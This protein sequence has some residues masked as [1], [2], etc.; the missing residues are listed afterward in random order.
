MTKGHC[1][2]FVIQV[3]LLTMPP[4]YGLYFQ[5][6][7]G[8]EPPTCKRRRRRCPWLWQRPKNTKRGGKLLPRPRSAHFSSQGA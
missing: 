4:P 8:L 5:G 6:G 2:E 1:A 3:W 7:W